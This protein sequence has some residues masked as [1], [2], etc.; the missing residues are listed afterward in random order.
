[1]KKYTQEEF[2]KFEIDEYGFKICPSGE[3]SLIKSFGDC[4][5]FGERCSFGEYCSFGEKCIF[6]E[7]C[8]FGER[9]SFGLWNSFNKPKF[10]NEKS[11]YFSKTVRSLKEVEE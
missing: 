5:S 9:C 2:N 3:Y 10:E 8:S 4:C 1:M 6:G 11:C 7:K